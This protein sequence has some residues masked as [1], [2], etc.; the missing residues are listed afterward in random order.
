MKMEKNKSAKV[1]F[2]TF[3][4]VALGLIIFVFLVFGLYYLFK[5]IGVA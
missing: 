3:I 5:K 4:K 1:E 2:E